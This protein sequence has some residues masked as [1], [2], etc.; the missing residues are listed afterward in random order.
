VHWNKAKKK[1]EAQIQKNGKQIYLGS[2]NDEE[3]AA[4]KYDEEAT[5]L[6][7]PLDFPSS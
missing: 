5:A 1:W 7:L 3:E 4:R 6:S 2:F